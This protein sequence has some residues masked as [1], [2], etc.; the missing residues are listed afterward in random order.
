MLDPS[1]RNGYYEFEYDDAIMFGSA[2]SCY[3]YYIKK[4]TERKFGELKEYWEVIDPETIESIKNCRRI[5]YFYK[6]TAKK[7]LRFSKRRDLK[8]I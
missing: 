8:E 3:W 5:I 6:P 1:K 2:A 4:S 7:V